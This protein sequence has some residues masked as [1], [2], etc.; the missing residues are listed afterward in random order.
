MSSSSLN[1][2]SGVWQ[3]KSVTHPSVSLYEQCPPGEVQ[4]SP[5]EGLCSGHVD[6][7]HSTQSGPQPGGTWVPL[8]EDASTTSFPHPSSHMRG[9]RAATIFDLMDSA[10]SE[11]GC[12]WR[13]QLRRSG[14]SGSRRPDECSAD[15]PLPRPARVR[16]H[17][18]LT[19]RP[20]SRHRVVDRRGEHRAAGAARVLRR[21][22]SVRFVWAEVIVP[23][24]PRARPGRGPR[25][26]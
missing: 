10:E 21:P 20:S 11:M 19:G 2:L 26:S 3:K 1:V 9:K 16:P 23:E 24:A 6:S 17:H 15:R 22:S 25:P 18:P 13:R 8:E 12:R 14:I 5:D 4:A 7:Q